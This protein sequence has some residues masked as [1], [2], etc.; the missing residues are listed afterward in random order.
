[1][2]YVILNKISSIVKNLS[3]GR[4]VPIS[5]KIISQM[6]YV[7]AVKVINAKTKYNILELES[8][9]MSTLQQ[10]DIIP[11][12]LGNR[13][14]MQGIYG[15][16]PPGLCVGGNIDILNIGGVAGECLDY[17]P[18]IGESVH[19][20]ILGAITDEAGNPLNL[21]DKKIIDHEE[22]LVES[23]K[24]IAVIGAGMNSGK[25]TVGSTIVQ[26][27]TS[28]NHTVAVAKISGVGAMRDIYGM[29]DHG[30]KVGVSFVDAGLP[31]TCI[32][33]KSLVIRSAKG[34]INYLAKTKPDTIF[35]EFGDGL[36]GNYGVKELL[37]D[38][39]I[40]NSISLCVLCAGDIPGAIKLYED[41]VALGLKPDII[42]GPVT[43]NI[44]GVNA[45]KNRLPVET[46]NSFRK[47]SIEVVVKILNGI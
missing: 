40:R 45:I 19:C 36:Y 42:A 39:E 17:N 44:I 11:V 6:G 7:L 30:A 2:N 16:I 4:E 25:T 32:E 21:L 31:S 41:C 22:N 38:K 5:D 10:G 27:L 43:D 47:N 26:I 12:V 28:E 3:L 24:L 46:F 15:I 33:D 13:F 37:M 20:K 14:A 23:Q 18:A 1:M 8:G 35:L 9:R 34:I 29:M